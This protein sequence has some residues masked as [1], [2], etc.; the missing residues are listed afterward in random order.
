M[1][2]RFPCRFGN[3][4]LGFLLQGLKVIVCDGGD[5]CKYVVVGVALDRV[6]AARRSLRRIS[7]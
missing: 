6:I 1:E 3:P 5:G 4:G 7:R 2:L